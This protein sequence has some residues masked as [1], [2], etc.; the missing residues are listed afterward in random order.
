M[1][2]EIVDARDDRV[3]GFGF[4]FNLVLGFRIVGSGLRAQ[5]FRVSGLGF[6]V[7]VLGS[8]VQGQGFG[9]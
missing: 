2:P 6:R 3:L 9:V 4:R 8:Q 5:R 1:S 7:Q